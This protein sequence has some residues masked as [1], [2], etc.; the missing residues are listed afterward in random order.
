MAPDMVHGGG[1][2]VPTVTARGVVGLTCKEEGRKAGATMDLRGGVAP[3][4]LVGEDSVSGA[5]L[6]AWGV[7][8]V[9]PG[10]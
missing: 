4:S 1:A 8:G 5:T 7:G 10:A 2:D 6:A 3:S 9:T